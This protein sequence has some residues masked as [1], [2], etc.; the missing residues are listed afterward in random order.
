[1]NK[2]AINH[3]LQSVVKTLR[4]NIDVKRRFAQSITH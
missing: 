3:C 1:M 4:R 2:V